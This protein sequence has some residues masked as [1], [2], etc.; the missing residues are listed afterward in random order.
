LYGDRFSKEGELALWI[1]LVGQ[2]VNLG[3]G[4]LGNVLNMGGMERL[5]LR[6]MAY[7]TVITSAGLVLLVPY[8][9]IAGVAAAT[10]AGLLF[11]KGAA[12]WVARRKLGIRW[13]DRRYLRWVIPGLVTIM[14]GILALLWGP[15]DPEASVLVLYLVLFYVVFHG[16]FFAQGLHEDDKALLDHLRKRLRVS[17]GGV[18]R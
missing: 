8:F 7:Q 18:V 5:M 2:V 12:M 11:N 14:T 1:L 9:G 13:G 4:P 10:T 16:V 6:L 15:Q 3:F 17:A